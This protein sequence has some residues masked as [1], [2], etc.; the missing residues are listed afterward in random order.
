MTFI[1]F[2]RHGEVHNPQQILYGRRPYFRLSAAG[3]LH[4]ERAAS[5]LRAYP[6]VAVYSSP[7]LRA[8]QTA[9]PIAASFGLSPRISLL[10]NE[11]STPYEGR[12]LAEFLSLPDPY[13]N[14]P[15]EYERPEDLLARV[16]RFIRREARRFPGQHVVA[17]T[18]GD[19][20]HTIWTWAG[21]ITVASPAPGQARTYPAPGSITS[22][23]VDAHGQ[24]LG[25]KYWDPGLA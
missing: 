23:Q 24:A 3:K 10:L 12:P 14:I 17:V 15:A 4:A 25:V 16:R 20:I 6:V 19:I 18:H 1:H 9:R 2:V 5:Y 7:L 8:R 21:F 13:S 11:V 22:V